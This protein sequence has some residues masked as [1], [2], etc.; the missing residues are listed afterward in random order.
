MGL[1]DYISRN[2]HNKAKP[3]G[4]YDED[5]VITQIDANIQT[6][7]AVKQR[8]K[9]RKLDKLELSDDSKSPIT[10]PEIKRQRGRPRKLPMQD[11]SKIK[12]LRAQSHKTKPRALQKLHNYSLRRNQELPNIEN[13]V[14]IDEA[15]SPKV[16][17]Q[18]GAKAHL[19]NN[20]ATDQSLLNSN[21]IFEMNQQQPPIQQSPPT[22]PAKSSISISTYLSPDK[23]DRPTKTD[24]QLDKAIRDVFSS[25]L[26]AA[27]T[28]RDSVLR[29]IRDC[30]TQG[31]ELRCKAV[32]RQIH[33]HWKQLS[34]ND[35]CIF[36]DNRLTIPNAVKDAVIDVLHATHPGAWGMTELAHR[37]W[38]PFINRD[39]INKSKT[40]RPCTEFGK[41]LKSIIPKTKCSPM[42]PCVEPNEE[43][44]I[45]FAGPI[46]DGQGREDI[47]FKT[48]KMAIIRANCFR[49]VDFVFTLLVSIL[50]FLYLF[51]LLY[52]RRLFL[53][54]IFS[55]Y[56]FENVIL[57]FPYHFSK[58]FFVPNGRIQRLR[59][60]F[61]Q[62]RF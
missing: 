12:V 39:L 58:K 18:T 24:S 45:D 51:F 28:N 48:F 15:K 50:I 30:I 4:R 40:C 59:F 32:S 53:L 26:I 61:M 1:T 22:S 20:F 33:T 57:Q 10:K 21:S 11:D 5:F 47:C 52:K 35:G 2:P 3:I 42:K 41:N 14:R 27:M 60:L 37:L 16:T 54:Y 36:L 55:I 13:H 56:L 43:I 49:F 23:E 6:I 31:D 44:Q 25:T 19:P 46:L 29:E 17:Q 34:V 8:G 62:T 9:P 38:W 7:N